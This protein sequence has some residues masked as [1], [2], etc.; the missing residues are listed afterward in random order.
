M[1]RTIASK[2]SM[3]PLTSTHRK[4]EATEGQGAQEAARRITLKAA[5]MTCWPLDM[6]SP[7]DAIRIIRAGDVEVLLSQSGG[8]LSS[9]KV[10]RQHGKRIISPKDQLRRKLSDGR[11]E[12][13]SVPEFPVVIAMYKPAGYVVTKS[14]AICD[15][16][17]SDQEKNISATS[18]YDLLTTS[19]LENPTLPPL[20]RR[21]SSQFRAVGRLDKDT[22]GLLLFTNQGRWITVLTTPS[23]RIPKMYRCWLLYPATDTDLHSWR[24]GGIRYRHRN[25]PQGLV[26]SLPAV[27]ADWIDLNDRHVMD[28][29]IVEGKYRQVRRCWEALSN[30]VVR[31]RRIAFGPIS[32][33][34]GETEQPGQCRVVSNSELH[35]LEMC[36]QSGANN[37]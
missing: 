11:F 6:S 30:K 16:N 9:W 4:N 8:D 7:V 14:N 24:Q 32:L 3:L 31:L 19:C 25:A 20:V 27:S 29:T 17:E 23:S 12:I 34:H 26:A 28:V 18:V 22:E 5:V 2:L 37:T 21:L 13:R 15:M 10:L 36:V 35:A 33:L 1:T